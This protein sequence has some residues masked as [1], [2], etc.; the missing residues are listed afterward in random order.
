MMIAYPKEP[1]WPFRAAEIHAASD[2][3]RQ[4]VPLLQAALRS[5]PRYAPAA[6][7]LSKLYYD[8]GAFD[9]AATLLEGFIA[10]DPDAPDAL[11]AALA[12]HLD[13]LGEPQRADSV[14]NA[15]ARN[16]KEARAA[17]TF[18]GLRGDDFQ[19]V[20]AGAKQ[21]VEDDPRSAASHNNY[22]IALLLQGRPIE[23][24]KAFLAALDL[25]ERLPGALY[26]MA[27]VEAF[28]FYDEEA[29]RRWFARYKER[30]TDDP[31]DLETYFGADLSKRSNASLKK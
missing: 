16:S 6:A 15:C 22:G 23:A 10:A 31:D 30:S 8:M 18:V 4:A 26:N 11:R 27:I 17:R 29:A 2:S 19:S 3:A 13:A 14:L 25:D 24:R 7:L 21:G 12:L 5:D 9:E 1:Y 28:F 20:L